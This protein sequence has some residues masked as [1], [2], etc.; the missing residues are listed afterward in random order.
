MGGILDNLRRVGFRCYG[1]SVS[2]EPLLIEPT[3]GRSIGYTSFEKP[4]PRTS[5]IAV[6]DALA[7][8]RPLFRYFLDGS[9]RTTNAGYIVDIKRRYLPL[10]I[11]QI[12]VAATN[13]EQGRICV[14][15]YVNRN[16]LFFPATFSEENTATA[17]ALVGD[18][19]LSSSC[20]FDLD[21]ECYELQDHQNPMDCARETILATMHRMEIDLIADLARS[22]KLTRDSLLMIDGSL[23]F[24]GNLEKE[25]EAFHNVVGVAKSFDLHQTIGSGSNAKAVGTIL[26]DLKHRYRT[27]AR[28]ITHR[29]LTI[30]AWYLRIHSAR[31][32]AG[33]GVTDGVVKIE[34]FPE[35]ATSRTPQLDANR[36]N[37][38]SEHVLALRHPSTPST[39][40]RWASHLYP[41]HITER[42]IKARFRTDQTMVACL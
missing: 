38:I 12:G 26:A 3:D 19:P 8:E 39:D 17:K 30:G 5:Q 42:Y 4:A 14:E 27:V 24:Y 1:P 37:T 36:C 13:L 11:G 7:G 33:L 18:A 22:G 16:F 6:Q 20:P 25:R 31:L 40:S 41:I 9:M 2:H 28:R 21:L 29:N 32:L 34:I 15:R 23:Q 35:K 10:F